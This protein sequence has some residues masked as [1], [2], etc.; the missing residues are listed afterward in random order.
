M[1]PH[2]SLDGA[3]PGPAIPQKKPKDGLE[4]TVIR[5]EYA[6]KANHDGEDDGRYIAQYGKGPAIGAADV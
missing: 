4:N 2:P 5:V 6:P 3:P 1:G